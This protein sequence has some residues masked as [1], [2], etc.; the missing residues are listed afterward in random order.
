MR[1]KLGELAPFPD[2]S[3]LLNALLCTEI[4]WGKEFSSVGIGE[5]GLPGLKG[6]R[7]GYFDRWL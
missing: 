6:I 5:E 3:D 7:P 4:N 2:P 1:N